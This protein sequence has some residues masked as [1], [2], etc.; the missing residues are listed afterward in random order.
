MGI[1]AW[2]W[3]DRTGFWVSAP[4]F[5]AFV[6]TFGHCMQQLG[7][8]EDCWNLWQGYGNDYQRDDNFEA[9]KALTESG[10]TFIDTAEARPTFLE[11]HTLIKF[12][13]PICAVEGPE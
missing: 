8:F 10:I 2:S 11:A 3:G 6:S 4:L 13:D 5:L 12:R 1:G 7:C 9:Y